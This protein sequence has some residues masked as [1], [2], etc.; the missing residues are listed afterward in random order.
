MKELILITCF[1]FNT[2]SFAAESID[3]CSGVAELYGHHQNPHEISQECLGIVKSYSN[4]K[5]SIFTKDQKFKIY[6][7]RNLIYVETYQ[8]SD[9][10]LSL[11]KT[12][13]LAG[14]QTKLKDVIAIKVDEDK[15]LLY[16]LN[17]NND[18]I[19][20]GH[21]KLNF[22][23]N[24]APLR[25]FEVSELIRPVDFDIDTSD[26]F[27]FF[28]DQ[29]DISIK[30]YFIHADINGNQTKHSTKVQGVISGNK[31][32]LLSPEKIIISGDLLHVWDNGSL[33][34][35]EKEKSGNIS[36]IN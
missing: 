36:P 8:V 5:T 26:G 35:F 33:I 13:V 30:K 32:T 7:Y 22:I 18:V 17:K 4:N 27:V 11:L 1:I 15:Q 31:T 20:F 24:V 34:K 21:Y 23:G 29:D 14:E 19:S 6:A 10:G 16:V 25:Y 12:E 2:L 28:I 9:L 3:S